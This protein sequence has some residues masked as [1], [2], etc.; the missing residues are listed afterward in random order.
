[1]ELYI[2]DDPDL[3][4][5]LLENKAN[6]EATSSL[7]FDR[8]EL[9][10]RKAS[11]I[12]LEKSVQFGNK[13]FWET[14]FEWLVDVMVK[15]KIALCKHIVNSKIDLKKKWKIKFIKSGILS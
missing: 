11:R 8:R 2:S 7:S 12:V 5:Y 13:N 9:P 6:I 3:Y 15:M 4:N 10:D 14:Q 1:M